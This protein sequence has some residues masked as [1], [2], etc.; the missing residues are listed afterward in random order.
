MSQAKPR[1]ELQRKAY[2]QRV[3]KMNPLS[4]AEH[5]MALRNRY[6]RVPKESQTDSVQSKN[7]SYEQ[8]E[9]VAGVISRI[10]NSF[11]KTEL[12]V[13]Q[14][15]LQGLPLKDF[16]DL[17]NAATRLLILAENRTL[18]AQLAAN[19]KFNRGFLNSL[20]EILVISQ[21][22]AAE[23]KDG[24]LQKLS[25]AA[26]AKHV[27]RSIKILEKEAP[28]IYDLEYEWFEILKAVKPYQAAKASQVQYSQSESS[29]GGWGWTIWIV[30]IIVLKILG[31]MARG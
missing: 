6:H 20:K 13:I 12:D 30:V 5:V 21:K 29:D 22:E 31:A 9:E 23:I 28:D 16:P 26:R 4:D 17:K 19:D 14:Q 15:R 11:W 24:V 8:R 1:S 25:V 18:F 10:R 2:L 3:L 7:V 27:R